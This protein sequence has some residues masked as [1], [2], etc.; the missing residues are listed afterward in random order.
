MFRNCIIVD[1]YR[2]QETAS[3]EYTNATPG[4]QAHL[5]SHQEMSVVR[6]YRTL[7]TVVD[8]IVFVHLALWVIVLELE[9]NICEAVY[10]VELFRIVSMNFVKVHVGADPPWGIRGSEGSWYGSGRERTHEEKTH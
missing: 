3:G 9:H 2:D 5:F 1:V 10:G 6:V 8:S 7:P 4:S